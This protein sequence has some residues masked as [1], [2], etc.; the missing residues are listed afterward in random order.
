VF[1][2]NRLRHLVSTG[3][4]E[5]RVIAPVPWFPFTH[6]A[7]G[8]YAA[9]ARM[10][11]R[12]VRSG[13]SVAHP[14]YVVIP[15]LGMSATP[16]ALYAATLPLLKRV[17][18]QFGFDLIDAHYFFPDGVAASWLGRALNVPVVI[19]ARGTDINL[20]PRHRVAR[21]MIVNAAN[22]AAGIIAVSQA[23]KDAMADLGMHADRIV[24][25]RNGVDLE[26]FRPDDRAAVRARLGV[27]GR[28]LL[29]VGHLIERKGHDIVIAALAQLPDCRLLVAGAGPEHARLQSLAFRLGIQDRVQF[30]GAVPHENLR[31]VYSAADALVLASS[32][33]GWPNVLLEAMACGTPVIASAVWGNPEVVS[34]A[35]A[36]LLMR[37]RTPEGISEAVNK[38]FEQP[39]DRN[40]T[41]AFAEKFSWN[42]TSLGQVRL[43]QNILKAGPTRIA[44]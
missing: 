37:D 4:V 35:E 33:E 11:A 14:R 32:R 38:L 30:L 34:G 12:E 39:I 10:P 42:E 16:C 40:A 21:R 43:F 18:R 13:I 7:F 2:E 5:A 20:I 9:L 15:K 26:T 28:V 44:S 8:D 31:A 29:S 1:V 23:L 6:T 22:R 24:V 36:G 3:L 27:Q 41:R 25:L 17:R 19:T